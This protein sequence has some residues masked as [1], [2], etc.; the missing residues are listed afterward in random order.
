MSYLHRTPLILT[1]NQPYVDW[2][3]RTDREHAMTLDLASTPAVYAVSEPE[4]EDGH[5]HVQTLEDILASRWQEIFDCELAGWCEDEDAW[6]VERSLDMFRSWFAVTLGHGLFD[7]DEDEP[8]TEDDLDAVEIEYAMNVC[9]WCGT[10]LSEERTAVPFL[11]ADREW[12]EERR[13]RV[14]SV[15]L[16]DEHVATGVVPDVGGNAGSGGDAGTPGNDV[17]FYACSSECEEA[18]NTH[19]PPA[20]ERRRSAN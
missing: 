8:L 11:M 1:R 19:V 12:L 17:I 2:A 3:N 7:L 16:D 18:L 10:D 4:S 6:P 9:G 5:E 13:G 14:I 20:L 15:V